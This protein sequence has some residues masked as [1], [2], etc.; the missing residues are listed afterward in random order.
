ML[1]ARGFE[2]AAT[3]GTALVPG[4]GGFDLAGRV[5]KVREGRPHV[6]DMI[7]NDEVA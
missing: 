4:R 7:K 6:V 2:I 3:G 1:I 5:N